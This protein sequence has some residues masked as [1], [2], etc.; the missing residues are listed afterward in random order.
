MLRT[1]MQSVK[2]NPAFWAPQAP[3]A[4][5]GGR[6]TSVRAPRGRPQNP[7]RSQA[8]KNGSDMAAAPRYVM[9]LVNG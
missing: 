5:A 9:S 8:R 2:Y 7:Q 4:G 6:R 1:H 3:T